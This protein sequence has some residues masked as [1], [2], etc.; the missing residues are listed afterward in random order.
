MIKQIALVA[1]A[2]EIE[3]L[4][5]IIQQN[6]P[7]SVREIC[8][9]LI[10]LLETEVDN[11]YDVTDLISLRSLL[12]NISFFAKLVVK[13]SPQRS[14]WWAEPLIKE[15]YS[16]SEIEEGRDILIIHANNDIGEFSLYPDILNFFHYRLGNLHQVKLDIYV[17]PAEVRFD[18][19]LVALIGHEVG[20]VYWQT[21][22]NLI[23][24]KVR[25]NLP[26][27]NL[28]DHNKM[29]E[30]SRRIASHI[31][32]YLCDLVGRYLMGPAFDFALLKLFLSLETSS[33]ETH[34]P[35][36][37]RVKKSKGSIESLIN[38]KHTCQEYLRK[39]YEQLPET[40]GG[41]ET[42]DKYDLLAEKIAN[43]IYE[44][45]GFTVESRMNRE[46]LDHIWGSVRPELDGFRPPFE[47]VNLSKPV[48]IPPTEAIIGSTIYFHGEAYKTT[49]QFYIGCFGSED[50]RKESLF[51]KLTEHLRY[52]ISL[53]GFVGFAHSRM[54]NFATWD[55]RNT[56]WILRKREHEG[57]SNAFV[58]TPTISPE[59][60]YSQNSVDLRLGSSFLVNQP[61]RYT[62][63]DPSIEVAPISSYYKAVNVPIGRKF[64]LHP[65]QF[66][67]ASV[68]EYISLPSDY[69]GL[70]LGRSSW[71]R[72]GLNIATATTIQAGF[73]GCLTLELRNLGESP[74]PLKVG[75]RI[76]QLCLI[77]VPVDS[78]THGYFQSKGKYI[79]PVAAEVPRIRKDPD[80]ELLHQFSPEEQ[81]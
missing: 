35:Q 49:N 59:N 14:S 81:Q 42:P 28:F 4:T 67:L 61:S 54:V 31:E 56:L 60:Q 52:A 69:Y 78:T 9:Q 5:E 24:G 37:S 6:I 8:K 30:A 68:L 25:E 33:N 80:W 29:E 36:V 21:R 23:E 41:T 34:P 47:T 12:K 13:A 46:K 39:M 44:F 17:I 18:I 74:L 71:G 7:E 20:H 75:A 2:P 26:D 45:N 70:V 16:L 65:H 19:S 57:R 48:A 27:P 3:E 79:G 63:I 58:V 64:I 62:H 40:S 10:L 43:E 15:C 55:W 11:V 51:Q 53:Y 66:V 77:R 72:L 50:E 38:I 1:I 32:E 22:R 73:R 76:A